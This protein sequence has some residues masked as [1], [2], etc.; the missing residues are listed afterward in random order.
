[1]SWSTRHGSNDDFMDQRRLQTTRKVARCALSQ[2]ARSAVPRQ[3]KVGARRFFYKH[4][5][6][7]PDI[8]PQDSTCR[9]RRA[10]VTSDTGPAC[11]SIARAGWAPAPAMPSAPCLQR[12]QRARGWPRSG[13]RQRYVAWFWHMVC[14]TTL[15]LSPPR[16]HGPSFT[17]CRNPT[18]GRARRRN[19]PPR[20]FR[21]D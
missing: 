6:Q 13:G 15:G 14:N 11:A 12:R 20:R 7:K 5:K 16:R 21:G 19:R 4:S 2:S 3:S 17:G 8:Y 1:M 9:D 18:P 10:Q